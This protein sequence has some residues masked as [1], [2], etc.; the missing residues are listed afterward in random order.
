M[1]I[2]DASCLFEAL[3][4]GS[5][6]QAVRS[7]LEG[8]SDLAAPHIIDV[9]VFAII[10]KTYLLGYL[11]STAASQAVEDL[12]LWSGERFAH[13]ALLGRAWE[14]RHAVRGW[15]AIY[16]ALAEALDGTLL[17]TDHRLARATGP[18]CSIE[19]I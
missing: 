11:D 10:R 5:A 18:R 2:V 4:A 1:L 6:A 12:R 16:V 14:L 17:T 8:D 13:G 15:D 3:T 7:R 9:E 19:V